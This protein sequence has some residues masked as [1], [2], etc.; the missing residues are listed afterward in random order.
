MYIKF[1]IEPNKSV[2]DFLIHLYKEVIL[3]GI[4]SKGKVKVILEYNQKKAFDDFVK[5]YRMLQDVNAFCGDVPIKVLLDDLFFRETNMIFPI[6]YASIKRF[7]KDRLYVKGINFQEILNLSDDIVNS[8][9]RWDKKIDL[10][11]DIFQQSR[12]AEGGHYH[13]GEN[14]SEL[15]HAAKMNQRFK[16]CLDNICSQV[17]KE[18]LTHFF[19]KNTDPSGI[20]SVSTNGYLIHHLD[21]EN[22]NYIFQ[23]L[24]PYMVQCIKKKNDHIK[25]KMQGFEEMAASKKMRE[26]LIN[27]TS[28][29]AVS[30]ESP[31]KI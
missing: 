9:L 8:S 18:K 28:Q 14:C 20:L 29:Y 3:K 26:E 17:S 6:P 10:I 19:S 2:D 30:S 21:A 31:K 7:F 24:T 25:S 4:Q 12:D 5:S 11:F 1:N 22:L 16:K 15:Q 13:P 27:A 23:Y